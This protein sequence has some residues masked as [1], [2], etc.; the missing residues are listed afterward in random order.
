[1]QNAVKMLIAD[2]ATHDSVAKETEGNSVGHKEG[3]M[4]NLASQN[5][6]GDGGG[7][8]LKTFMALRTLE[9]S[10]GTDAIMVENWMKSI[11]KHLRATGCNE[12]KKVRL[13]TFLL[14]GKAE[15]WWEMAR[16]RYGSREP[17]WLEFQEAF[18]DN[19]FPSWMREQKVY[20]F[21]ELTQGT[22]TVAQ[23]E[24]EFISLAKFVIELVSSES[25][26]ATKFQLGLRPKIRYTLAYARIADYSTIVQRVYAIEKD[27]VEMGI[28]QPPS[29]GV[30][31]SQ[32]K[33][34]NKKRE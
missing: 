6:G 25:N 16:Q 12:A 34:G 23:Y 2:Q 29:K 14:A 28:D 17:T 30:G 18:N 1:M 27:R 32:G 26:K 9:F 22:K 5:I 8:L 15:R 31:S 24:V 13:V 3:Q 19:Y 4:Q 20:E 10:G 11:E 7:Q 21:I 33:N